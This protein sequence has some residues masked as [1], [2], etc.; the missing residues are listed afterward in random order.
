MPLDQRQDGRHPFVLGGHGVDQGLA[1][2]CGQARLEYLDDGGV[3][4]E[5]QVAQRL[6]ELDGLHHQLDLVREWRSH[7]DVE[8]HRTACDLLSHIDFNAR[9]V[10]AP[11]LLLED[12]PTGG[13][14]ALADD[15]ERVVPADPHLPG[16]RRHD[17]FHDV[18][19]ADATA[20]RRWRS[21][22]ARTT[23]ADA[24]AAYPSAPTTLAYSWVTGA[25]PTMTMT[26][27]RMP[28]FSSALMF[29]LNIGIVVVKNAEKPTMSGSC[30]R[31]AS[32][33]FS[34]ATCTPRSITS[35][36]APSNMMFTRFLPMSCTSPLTVPMTILPIVCAPVSASNGLRIASA[37]A[38][39][40]PAIS[41]SGTKKS[42]R[43]NRA[44]T[45]SRAGISASYSSVSGPMPSSSPC[46]VR[47]STSGALPT[48]VCSYSPLRMSSWL[49]RRLPQCECWCECWCE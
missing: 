29:A 5:R 38:I 20:R 6:D 30:S 24:S 41:I 35:K 4:A 1:L 37:P 46:R 31:M 49:M 39:A 2:I 32:R 7:V 10:A 36:P 13:V 11:Q 17:G 22:L 21:S 42:P 8:H 28:A 18:A 45:S 44:P 47:A 34:G 33:N 3:Q 27:S 43:S 23:A 15:A 16:R 48:S 26:R 9:Q 14:D 19:H 12:F 40:L 25:P